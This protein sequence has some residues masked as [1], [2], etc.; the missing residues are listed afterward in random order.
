M[1][2]IHG[3]GTQGVSIWTTGETLPHG[4]GW[5]DLLNPTAD[6]QAA[7]EALINASLPE[8]GEI[9]SLGLSSRRQDDGRVMSLHVHLYADHPHGASE[10]LGMLVTDEQL[11]TL[12][13]QSSRP[14]DQ[15]AAG[16]RE[17]S[18]GTGGADLLVT[19][20]D[21]VV[22]DV[23]DQMQRIAGDVAQLSDDVFSV[24]HE[25]TR[26]LRKKL[27]R[28]GQLEGRLAR[29]RGSLL[30]F[31]RVVGFVQHRAPDW[32]DDDVMACVKV[33]ASDLDVLDEFDDQLTDK[34]QFLQ[35]GVLGFISTDQNAV[36][37]LLTVAS[38]VTIPPVILAG[39]WG[40]NFRHMPALDKVWGYPMALAA[41]VVSIAL[42]LVWFGVRG[43]LSRD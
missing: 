27:V 16:L 32:M 38:V 3:H 29:Y 36:M 41:L 6:E 21:A 7:V 23:A 14:F 2:T 10:P 9:N 18:R 28:I 43:W 1:L 11:V 22:D 24:T 20:L 19:L 17:G 34:L 26:E 42:P 15:A 4:P 5:L 40:M 33:L 39:I 31:G 37:K 13:Y 25:R 8:R 35:D 12:R 30:G